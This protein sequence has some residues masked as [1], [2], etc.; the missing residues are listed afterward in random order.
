MVRPAQLLHEPRPVAP[1]RPAATV[2]LLRDS[3]D[4]R[5]W[6]EYYVDESW[7][8]HLRRFDRVTAADVRLRERRV[9][10][11]RGETPPRVSRLIAQEL[12]R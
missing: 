3:A 12:P 2:L 9:S 6:V 11:H 5:R 8:E 7:T 1:V 4:P 10:F